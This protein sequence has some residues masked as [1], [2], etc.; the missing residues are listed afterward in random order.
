MLYILKS[1]GLGLCCLTLVGCMNLG[2]LSYQ[3]AKMLKK[4][5]FEF[6]S[7]GWMLGL[8]ERLLF[9]FNVADVN[10]Q[11]VGQLNTLAIQLKKY[12]LNRLKIFGYTDNVGS[13]QYNL[14]LS[15]QRA[16]HV[17][18]Y[19]LANGYLPANLQIIGRG[20]ANPINENDTE[21]NRAKNRRVSIV[22]VP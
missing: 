14:N 15:Q 9:D 22:V 4:Q 11:Y 13:E 12:N 7:E 18:Q 1:I 10:P 2:G 21:D 16:E 19:F 20:S 5:G 8:P 3:Q 6:T 17:S